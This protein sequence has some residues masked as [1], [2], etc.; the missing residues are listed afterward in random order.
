MDEALRFTEPGA[1]EVLGRG[2]ASVTG[3]PDKQRGSPRRAFIVLDDAWAH[4]AILRGDFRSVRTRE[5]GDI[6]LAYFADTFGLD[7]G[8]ILT[9]WQLQRG[10][11][12]LFASAMSRSLHDGILEVSAAAHVD[13]KHLTVGLPECL[14][15]V[16]RGVD[17]HKAL[18][19]VV[20]ETLLQVVA[21]DHGRWA[22]YD[23]QRL[24]ADD[25]ADAA[26]LVGIVDH[27]LE[28]SSMRQQEDGKVYLCGLA[29]DPAPFQERFSGALQLPAF[30][31]ADPPAVRLMGLAQ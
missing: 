25:A 10:G 17:D 8:A 28:R 19:L 21:A 1:L 24:F 26:R 5:L 31:T 13:V 11:R 23:A 6:T 16:R 22:A 27:V 14:D 20:T 3:A 2:L 12:A 18:L 4:H 29:V 7:A 15:Q 9:R 30:A